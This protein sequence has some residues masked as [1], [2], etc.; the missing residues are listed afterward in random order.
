VLID[1]DITT[2]G[3]GRTD[4]GVH[5]RQFYAHFDLNDEL[6]FNEKLIYSLNAILPDDIVVDDIIKVENDAHARY[7]AV[8]RTYE[9]FIAYGKEPFLR[10]FTLHSYSDYNIDKMNECC[11][12]LM[13]HS[14]FSSFSKSNTQVKTNICKITEAKWEHRCG[15][16]VFT[17]TADRFLRGMVRAIVGTM[18]DAGTGK[19]E[20]AGIDAILKSKNR[21]EAGVSVPACGLYLTEVIYPYLPLVKAFKFPC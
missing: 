16:L 6:V 13:A 15:L 9:Y 21:A 17:I 4:T 14:D 8:S 11:S 7:D 2:T 18:L 3:C 12:Y 5:A 10:E 19:M 1:K 20:P